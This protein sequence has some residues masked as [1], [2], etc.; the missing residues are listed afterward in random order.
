M[1]KKGYRIG[2][3][4]SVYRALALIYR[5]RGPGVRLSIDNPILENIDGR[6]AMFDVSGI[7]VSTHPLLMPFKIA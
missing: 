4:S 6:Y 7:D 5:S 2:Y 1:L 3:L